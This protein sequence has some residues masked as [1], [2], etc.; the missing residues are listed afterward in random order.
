MLQT[1]F[2]PVR[3]TDAKSA[4]WARPPSSVYSTVIRPNLST[5]GLSP[6]QEHPA[7]QSCLFAPQLQ[8]WVC[9]HR[10]GWPQ[11]QKYLLILKVKTSNRGC[12]QNATMSLFNHIFCILWH[13]DILG[14]SLTGKSHPLAANSIFFFFLVWIFVKAFFFFFLY[15]DIAN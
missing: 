13:F 4:S 2:L 10:G 9:T 8:Q 5:W 3:A 7:L 15:W 14:A 6:A 12:S 1:P 11:A